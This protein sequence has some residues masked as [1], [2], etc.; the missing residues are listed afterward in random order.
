[1]IMSIYCLKIK[2]SFYGTKYE[3]RNNLFSCA[4]F[5]A[6]ALQ[7]LNSINFNLCSLIHHVQEH[8]NTLLL[9]LNYYLK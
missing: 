4:F 3:K 7:K 5:F 8:Q 6:H 9:D 1:M 2:I